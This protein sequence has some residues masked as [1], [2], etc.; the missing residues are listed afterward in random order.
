M[1]T[2][3]KYAIDALLE[4]VGTI[5][6]IERVYADPPEALSE[7][8]CAIAYVS[9]G[10]LS[11]FPG[12]YCTHN[13]MLEIHHSRQ[14]L[15]TA[16]DEAKAWPDLVLTALVADGTFDGFVEAVVWPVTYDA[17]ALGYN[18]ET[19]YGIRFRIPLM[20]YNDAH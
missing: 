5:P 2:P 9:S 3:L 16:I 13:I 1:T 8:P 6:G 20:L 18:S 19:H 12:A 15:Q 10:E 14:I 11:Y 17:L 7:F 4:A